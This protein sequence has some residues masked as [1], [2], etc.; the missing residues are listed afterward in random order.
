MLLFG[1]VA[2]SR[3]PPARILLLTVFLFPPIRQLVARYFHFG[4]EFQRY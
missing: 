2:I 3:K 1:L 4:F